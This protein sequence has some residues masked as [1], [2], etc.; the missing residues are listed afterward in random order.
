MRETF[1]NLAKALS[2][3]LFLFFAHKASFF[4]YGS[5]FTAL[6]LQVWVIGSLSLTVFFIGKAIKINAVIP[7]ALIIL[8][9]LFFIASFRSPAQSAAINGTFTDFLR[10]MYFERC[11]NVYFDDVNNFRYDSTLFYT[12]PPGDHT[13]SNLEFKTRYHVNQMGFR[14][15]SASL[16]KPEIVFLGDSYTMGWGIEKPETFEDLI[17]KE[18][19]RKCLNTGIASYGTARELL[20]LDRLDLSAC[21]LLVLQFCK[22]DRMENRTFVEH[23]NFLPISDKEKLKSSG[24]WNHLW[25]SYFPLKY[26]YVS[27]F[28]LCEQL[29]LALF[30]SQ[31]PPLPFELEE[32]EVTDFF[33]I[34]RQIRERFDGPVLIFNI[35][36]HHEPSLIYQQFQQHL[37]T[38]PME[39]LHLLPFDSFLSPEDYFVIDDHLNASGHRKLADHLKEYILGLQL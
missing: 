29:K 20:T 28:Q 39:G 38:N 26:C 5:D 1:K 14:D 16:I 17:E 35:N 34:L 31:P 33:I 36:E 21:K 4:F 10:Q 37:R 12:L 30:A 32:Q 13:F 23:G 19:G 25:R 24:D 6:L 22:N 11:R 9:E 8:V 18:L 15:D 2:S 3:F 27:F 7:L